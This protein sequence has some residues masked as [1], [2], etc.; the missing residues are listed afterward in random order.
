[1][2]FLAYL[3]H[4]NSSNTYIFIRNIYFSSD[5]M[6][7][8]LLNTRIEALELNLKKIQDELIV[9]KNRLSDGAEERLNI[10]EDHDTNNESDEKSIHTNIET[11]DKQGEKDRSN[12]VRQ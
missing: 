1:V 9:E 12:P 4:I 11:I 10:V 8:T 7:S 2:L 6:R 3:T 5:D